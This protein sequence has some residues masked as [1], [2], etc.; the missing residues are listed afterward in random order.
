MSLAEFQHSPFA[1]KIKPLSLNFVDFE[2][3]I[4]QMEFDT[5]PRYMKGRDTVGELNHFLETVVIRCF[6]DKYTLVY[7]NREAVKIADKNLWCTYRQ[8]INYF[9]GFKFITQGDISRSLARLIDK[10]TSN[11]I[12]MLKHLRVLKESR[13]ERTICYLWNVN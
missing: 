12:T 3:E 7:K 9:P 2:K 4:T 10:K 11:R 6:N 1:K 13:E 5:I 8:Q